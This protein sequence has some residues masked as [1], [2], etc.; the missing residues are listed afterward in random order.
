MKGLQ[1]LLEGKI[2]QVLGKL[3]YS[4]Y[5]LHIPFIFSISCY[6]LKVVLESGMAYLPGVGIVFLMSLAGVLALAYVYNR[7]IEKGCSVL[8]NKILSVCYIKENK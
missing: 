1:H 4:I 6:M 8:L 3:S 5:I 2:A 7:Y